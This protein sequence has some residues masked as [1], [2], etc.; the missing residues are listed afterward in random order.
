MGSG[1]KVFW[2]NHA[3]NELAETYIY[4]ENNFN[5]RELKK[6]SISLDKTLKLISKFPEMFPLSNH[7]QIRRVIIK[8]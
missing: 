6:L 7:K 2:T 1:Y 3:L 4:L 8:K 5:A